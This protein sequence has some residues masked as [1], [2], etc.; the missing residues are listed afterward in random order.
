FYEVVIIGED[1]DEKV[2][3][4]NKNYLPNKIIAG[5]REENNGPLFQNRFVPNET[6]I[7]V[8]KNNTCKLPIKDPKIAI[9]SL[10]KNE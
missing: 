1:V 9:E 5:S 3:N 6:L 10:N 2:K 7:Y 8:C 4:I